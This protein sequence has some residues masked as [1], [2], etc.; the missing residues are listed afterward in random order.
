[1]RPAPLA[2]ALAL[3]AMPAAG[4]AD[5]PPDEALGPPPAAAALYVHPIQRFA[6]PPPEGWTPQTWTGGVRLARGN[7]AINVAVV[8][9]TTPDDLV[10]RVLAAAGDGTKAEQAEARLADRQAAAVTF[11]SNDAD[12]AARR[13]RMLVAATMTGALVVGG[14]FPAKEFDAGVEVLAA[15][16]EGL[17][18]NVDPADAYPLDAPASR[19]ETKAPQTPP[20]NPGD[21]PPADDA[22]A[23]AN[24]LKRDGLAF[25]CRYPAGL[26][27]DFPKAGAVRFTGPDDTAME[28]VFVVFQDLGVA[29]KDVTPAAAAEG[30]GKRILA[31]DAK[32]KLGENRPRKTGGGALA[33]VE[34]DGAWTT[35]DG[36]PMRQVVAV[37]RDAGN[38]YY[39]AMG[40]A[41]A[42]DFAAHRGV[43]EAM[44]DS[45]R[46][47]E[48][49]GGRP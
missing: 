34:F 39:L 23:L 8:D 9:R 21:A 22:P 16:A 7:S 48:P 27:P 15:V 49:E 37:L 38:R 32:A 2:L 29:E 20:A 40:V 4:F 5:D 14:D 31:T 45:L 11:D 30:V 1:M 6:F 12:G 44:F 24:E 19:D 47:A 42:D 46:P 13:T 18:L 36:V 25:T 28:Y 35:A 43:I 26:R 17:R 10:K 41:P 3:A 33:G